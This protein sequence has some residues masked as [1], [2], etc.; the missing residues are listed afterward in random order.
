M[1]LQKAMQ[2][3]MEKEI[4]EEME[5]ISDDPLPKFLTLLFARITKDETSFCRIDWVPPQ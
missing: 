4:C 2:E 1:I 5:K 3:K